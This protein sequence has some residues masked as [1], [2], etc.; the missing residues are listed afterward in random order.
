MGHHCLVTQERASLSLR[1]LWHRLTG[2]LSCFLLEEIVQL[3]LNAHTTLSDPH[4]KKERAAYLHWE[5][6]HDWMSTHGCR[7]QRP[8]ST[9]PTSLFRTSNNLTSMGHHCLV[10]QERAS[11]SLRPLWHRLT[12]HLSCFLLEEIVQLTLNAHT[13]LS[14]PHAK[15]ERAAYLHWECSHLYMSCRTWI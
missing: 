2:H 8:P 12:G 6:S 4:A 13:T 11:L 10:T 9:P 1:P 7:V 5:C 14:D 3:T 15:K